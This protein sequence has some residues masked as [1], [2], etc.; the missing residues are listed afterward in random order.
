MLDGPFTI[1]IPKES[2][3]KADPMFPEEPDVFLLKALYPMM[4]RL[5]FNVPD[6]VSHVRC[7]DRK[8]SIARVPGELSQCSKCVMD[9]G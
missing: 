6:C 7:T 1:S 3:F 4:F 8:C 2:F 5:I 9:P